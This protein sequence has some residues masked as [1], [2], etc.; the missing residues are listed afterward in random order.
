MIRKTLF[1]IIVLL[2]GLSTFAQTLTVTKEFTL[3][4]NS[5]VLAMYKNQFGKWE[6]PDMDDT[7]PYAVIR[8]RLEGNAREVT[9][10]KQR[11]TLYLGTQTA[12][13]D[14]YAQNS[15]ELLF[16]VPAR[17]PTIYIDC[18]DGCDKV[19][20]MENQ[21]LQSNR[22][23][24]GVV[25]FVPE[26]G[27]STIVNQGPVLHPFKLR[28]T[29]ANAQVIVVSSGI[30]QEWI[31]ENGE[32]N[33]NIMAGQYRYTISAP[34]YITQEGTLIVDAAHSDTTINLISKFGTL[35][36]TH[37]DTTLM[38]DVK[39]IGAANATY[40]VPLKEVR[41]V[42][43]TYILSVKKLRHIPWT[44]TLEI[45]AGD[46]IALSPVLLPKEKDP[47]NEREVKII[48][49]DSMNNY[50][51]YAFNAKIKTLVMGQIGY[52]VA[53][54]LS[55]GAMIGQMYKGYGWYVSGRSNFSFDA[56]TIIA[57]CDEDGMIDGVKPFF[58]GNTHI[59][60]FA[61]HGGFMMNFLEK[62]TK[63]KFTTLGAYVGGGYGKRQLVAET[64]NGEWIKYAPTSHN[65]FAA[66]VGLFGSVAGV[67]LNVGVST[68]NFKYMDFE[69]GIGFMF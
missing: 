7:F 8:M 11:L 12:V 38:V 68:I 62:V 23:Y 44:D 25:H 56:P 17:R 59:T 66:N 60:H 18:G 27:L 58:S 4:P 30:R 40:P 5:S 1:T 61:V 37:E 28:V 31:L 6:K 65:G 15:N 20:L 52:S 26:E 16:L 55:Y 47:K 41:C 46:N 33:L 42:P 14:R 36:I 21:Q 63:N 48:L 53:P 67:T 51:R 13:V 43:G 2:F 3:V 9:M 39:R 24:D 19:L 50:Q 57:S 10:A 64:A 32:A 69:L 45:K 34:E 35:T 22:V 54:Q 29:P 49:V